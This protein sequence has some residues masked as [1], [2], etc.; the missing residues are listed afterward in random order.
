MEPGGYY[1]EDINFVTVNLE[2][3][4]FTGIENPEYNRRFYSSGVQWSDRLE[5]FIINAGS[6]IYV[7][8]GTNPMSPFDEQREVFAGNF[9]FSH[10]ERYISFR[11]CR[12]DTSCIM[13]MDENTISTELSIVWNEWETKPDKFSWHPDD[14]NWL[15]YFV[16]GKHRIRL[17]GSWQCRG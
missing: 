3:N 12:G 6:N 4:S 5:A 16:L 17:S 11:N 1:R 14:D 15:I 7:Y 8:D 10:T 9:S 2:T 13:D